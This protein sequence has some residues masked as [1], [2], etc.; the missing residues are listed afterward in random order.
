MTCPFCSTTFATLPIFCPN[1]KNTLPPLELILIYARL[2]ST[3][4]ELVKVENREELERLAREEYEV[5]HRLIAT[6]KAQ[7]LENERIAKIEESIKREKQSKEKLERQLAAKEK[8]GKI[9]RRLSIALAVIALGSGTLFSVMYSVD[10]VKQNT[11]DKDC[12]NYVK[13]DDKNQSD[14]IVTLIEIDGIASSAIW[15]KSSDRFDYK[16]A[17]TELSQQKSKLVSHVG[18]FET[19]EVK[20]FHDKLMKSNLEL[21]DNFKKARLGQTSINSRK[22]ILAINDSALEVRQILEGSVCDLISERIV[23]ARQNLELNQERKSRFLIGTKG[24]AAVGEEEVITSGANKPTSPKP[25]SSDSPEQ[26]RARLRD[27]LIKNGG[28][29][30]VDIGRVGVSPKEGLCVKVAQYPEVK[31]SRGITREATERFYVSFSSNPNEDE[32]DDKHQ[33]RIREYC[34]YY[35]GTDYLGTYRFFKLGTFVYTESGVVAIGYNPQ[36]YVRWDAAG[37]YQIWHEAMLSKVISIFG[38]TEACPPREA[39]Q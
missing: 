12:R 3:N 17:K 13:F 35:D 24:D 7:A 27:R 34:R 10:K 14:A 5:R 23:Q 22:L 28:D 30:K 16:V 20:S 15:N 18:K 26:I 11:I 37:D 2:L 25:I 32:L 4:R 31:F 19:E 1:C 38:G 33:S 39:R 21:E 8:Q 36:A 6:A 9:L 29:C